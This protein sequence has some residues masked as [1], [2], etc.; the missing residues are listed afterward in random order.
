VQPRLTG[1]Q[2][3]QNRIARLRTPDGLATR[4]CTPYGYGTIS[5]SASRRRNHNMEHY[6]V[7]I[8]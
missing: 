2:R 5:I 7:S 4:F 1:V 8:N 6:D 3:A